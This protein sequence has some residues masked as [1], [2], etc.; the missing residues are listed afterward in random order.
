MYALVKMDPVK[1][2]IHPFPPVSR[3]SLSCERLQTR[4]IETRSRVE[5]K[6]CSYVKDQFSREARCRP[7]QV[8]EQQSRFP[9]GGLDI[10]R[11]LKYFKLSLLQLVDG[12]AQKKPGKIATGDPKS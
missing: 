4:K 12:K 6:C 3:G 7:A 1:R 2:K 8:P 5:E 9:A 11:A 10:H